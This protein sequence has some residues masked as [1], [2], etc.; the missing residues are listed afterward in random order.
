MSCHLSW[1]LGT[2]FFLHLS[3]ILFFSQI[4]YLLP[5]MEMTDF[6]NHAF[7]W[8]QYSSVV[9]KMFTEEISIIGLKRLLSPNVFKISWKIL[10]LCFLNLSSTMVWSMKSSTIFNASVGKTP[11]RNQWRL[12]KI[13]LVGVVVIQR[14]PLN[15]TFFNIGNILV[16]KKFL[17]MCEEGVL[18]WYT[19]SRCYIYQLPNSS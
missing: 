6:R 3:G 8:I 12:I 2:I 17:S 4:I 5:S 15:C 13:T 9:P 7:C 16:T 10:R 19:G 11:V 18:H 1:E 14:V